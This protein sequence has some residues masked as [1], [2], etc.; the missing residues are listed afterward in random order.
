[1]VFALLYAETGEPRLPLM[2]S[3]IEAQLDRVGF[4]VFTRGVDPGALMNQMRR[5]EYDAYLAGWTESYP[6]NPDQSHLFTHSG[7][8][9]EEGFN[10]GSYY[11]ETVEALMAQARNLP[12][13]DYEARAEIYRQIQV[14]L[15]EDQPYVWLFAPNT[16]VAA[17]GSVIGF[18][19][20]PNAPFWNVRDWLVFD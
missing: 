1:M 3:L 8:V 13:C 10:T 7:D 18:D 4:N 20:Y 2:A 12:D 9:L 15:Q 6:V 5:Q 14:I 11:N 16:L 19:P 17:R